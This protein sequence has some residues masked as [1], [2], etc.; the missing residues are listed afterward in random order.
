MPEE[1]AVTTPTTSTTPASTPAPNTLEARTPDGTLRDQ[2]S[3]QTVTT[4]SNEPATT[5]TTPPEG[6][7]EA[8]AAFKAPEGRELD[9]SF[10]DKATPVFKEL[11]L[12]QAAA[13]K[14]V[15]TWND[16]AKS[17]ADLAVKAVEQMREGWRADFAKS[18]L[19]EKLDTIK[20]DIGKMKDTIFAGAPAKRKAFEDAMDLTGAGD[21]AAIIETIWDLSRS[22]IEP[23][24]VSGYGPS[25]EGQRNPAAPARPSAAQSMYPNLPSVQTS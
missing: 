10:L 22:H 6:A 24:H 20:E 13:Q 14:L 17:Q 23:R 4:P 21:H 1:S 8:Y 18:P 5:A 19:G 2:T 7:P 11:N 15:D 3:T 12:P 25:T 16:L 9:K